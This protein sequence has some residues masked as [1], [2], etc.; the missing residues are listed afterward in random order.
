M[1]TI[2]L[3]VKIN[4]TVGVQIPIEHITDALNKIPVTERWN[5]ASQILNQLNLA[6]T[7]L[8]PVQKAYV[9]EYVR[10]LSVSFEANVQT[11]EQKA[12]AEAEKKKTLI[13]LLLWMHYDGNC[14]FSIDQFEGFVLTFL[15]A[16]SGDYEF[17][18]CKDKGKA[19]N[20]IWDEWHC[21]YCL[22]PIKTI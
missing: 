5:A 17:C 7:S 9:Q 6:I 19:V 22:K 4:E 2:E 16:T 8:Q 3:K 15:A 13:N 20:H 11:A 12:Q 1:E 18:H 10:R 21:T 14:K